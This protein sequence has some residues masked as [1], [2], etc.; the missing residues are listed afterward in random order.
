M[1]YSND[2]RH[3]TFKRQSK[4]SKMKHSINFVVIVEGYCVDGVIRKRVL[5]FNLFHLVV[6]RFLY[7]NRFSA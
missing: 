2:I 5:L 1:T 3:L 6:F 4:Q 7:E